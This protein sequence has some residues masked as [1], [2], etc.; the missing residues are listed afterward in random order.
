MFPLLRDNF[1]NV[2]VGCDISENNMVLYLHNA[3]SQMQNYI[4][5]ELF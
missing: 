3:K 2:V 4:R 1:V 5:A